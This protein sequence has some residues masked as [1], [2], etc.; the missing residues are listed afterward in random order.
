MSKKVETAVTHYLHTWKTQGINA[1]QDWL[2]LEDKVVEKL[3][4]LLGAFQAEISITPS[5]TI[6]LHQLMSTFYKPK[7]NRNKILMLA[8]EFPSDIFCVQSWLD[9]H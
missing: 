1:W 2:P 4:F 8:S 5:L 9:I 3:S 6:G 7:P